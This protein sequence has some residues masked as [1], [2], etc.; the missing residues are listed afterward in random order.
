MK[1]LQEGRTGFSP[2]KGI[3][4]LPLVSR[5]SISSIAKARSGGH[6]GGRQTKIHI[7]GICYNPATVSVMGVEPASRDMYFYARAISI[8]IIRR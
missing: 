3:G 2:G 6:S 1:K 8:N 4:A 5:F 7:D